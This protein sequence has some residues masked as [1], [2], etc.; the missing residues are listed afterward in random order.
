MAISFITTALRQSVAKPYGNGLISCCE[1]LELNGA[2]FTPCGIPVLPFCTSE[3]VAI[4]N[5]FPISLDIKMLALRLEP[6]C[7]SPLSEL[8]KS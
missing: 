4:L 6:M 7:I 2:V 8:R 3:L 1:V 5:S